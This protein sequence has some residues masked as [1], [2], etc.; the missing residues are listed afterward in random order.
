MNTT[1]L[2]AFRHLDAG[3]AGFSDLALDHT[4]D[5]VDDATW[6]AAIEERLR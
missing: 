2:V 1:N 5:S 3:A 6:T 4:P